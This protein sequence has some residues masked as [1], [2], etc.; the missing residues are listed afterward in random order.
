MLHFEVTLFNGNFPKTILVVL[1]GS[2]K[3]SA[4]KWRLKVF[5]KI[6]LL[7]TN[8]YHH[9]FTSKHL[10]EVQLASSEAIAQQVL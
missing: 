7:S 6:T 1:N 4:I 5:L 2:S 8:Q 10:Q 9:N 3:R